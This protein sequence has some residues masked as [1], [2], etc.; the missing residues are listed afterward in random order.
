MASSSL[1]P[2]AEKWVLHEWDPQLLTFREFG[3]AKRRRH[4][5][6]YCVGSLVQVNRA[7]D[8]VWIC[9]QQTPPQIFAQY[10]DRRRTGFAVVRKEH[11]PRKRLL[12][13]NREEFWSDDRSVY[14][15]RLSSARQSELMVL[16]TRHG[17]K[18]V[19][20]PAQFHKVRIRPTR[21]RDSFLRF[22]LKHIEQ[23]FGIHV[24]QRL[25]QYRINDTENGRVRPDAERKR[26]YGDSSEAGSL[27]QRAE[28]VAR[29]LQECFDHGQALEFAVG[30]FQL[31]EAS[32]AHASG[33]LGFMW[34]HASPDIF[35]R[36]HFETDL[37]LILEVLTY[38]MG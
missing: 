12:A 2:A 19:I 13:E 14:D 20:L 28:G 36:E 23:L 15:R 8:D 35:V 38:A 31:C 5:S 25:Q 1:H 6:N 37:K 24:R 7:S 4:D 3:K 17:T 10:D 16:T 21:S 26:K 22:R 30:L 29:V 34:R 18:N 27:P 32:Q 9:S 11:A 33:A